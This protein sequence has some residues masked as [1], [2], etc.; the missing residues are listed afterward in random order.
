MADADSLYRD[1][2]EAFRRGDFEG[3]VEILSRAVDRDAKHADALRTLGMAYF[4]LERFAEA[5]ATGRRLV[6]AAPDEIL[7][8]TT[9]SLFLQKMGHI[10]EAEAAAARARLLTWKKQLR[11]GGEDAPGLE[12]LDAAPE[13]PPIMPLMPGPQAPPA[14][15]ESRPEDPPDE[16][17]RNDPT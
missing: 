3:A 4:R 10:E 8:Y 14:S 11:E 7:S 6:E 13:S 5:L 9:L 2:F 15:D 12:I 17:R 16:P 1:G